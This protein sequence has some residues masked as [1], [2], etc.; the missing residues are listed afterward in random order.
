[1]VLSFR[2]TLFIFPWSHHILPLLPSWSIFWAWLWLLANFFST[3][4]NRI[5]H[6]LSMECPPISHYTSQFQNILYISLLE[7]F[8]DSSRLARCPYQVLSWIPV[9]FLILLQLTTSTFLFFTF[10]PSTK[11]EVVFWKRC[12]TKATDT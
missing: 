10:H 11:M 3:F 4:K 6:L 5:Y 2:R 8:S 1:M 12:H 9:F 7:T